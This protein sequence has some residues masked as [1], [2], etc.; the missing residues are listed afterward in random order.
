MSADIKYGVMWRVHFKWK[1][2]LMID[3]RRRRNIF[4]QIIKV[5]NIITVIDSKKKNKIQVYYKMFCTFIQLQLMF[6]H[7]LQWKHLH[8]TILLCQFY[9]RETVMETQLMSSPLF[10]QTSMSKAHFE[11]HFFQTGYPDWLQNVILLE[12]RCCFIDKQLFPSTHTD[13]I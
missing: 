1:W 5:E 3:R 9:L 8:I 4:S 2:H 12:T 7:I 11:L 10:G 13:T 6:C